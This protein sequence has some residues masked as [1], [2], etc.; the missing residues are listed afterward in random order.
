MRFGLMAALCG[1]SASVE[2][3]GD[4]PETMECPDSTPDPVPA[5]PVPVDPLPAVDEDARAELAVDTALEAWALRG[6]A[7]RQGCDERPA[8][9]RLASVEALMVTCE[10]ADA[11]T[12]CTHLGDEAIYLAPDTKVDAHGEPVSRGTILWALGCRSALHPEEHDDSD[13]VH[14]VASGGATT[15]QA[16]AWS[17]FEH[18]D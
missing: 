4:M 12:H 17:L 8:I 18:A 2:F 11:T 10:S 9:I 5:D 13:P 1:C 3:P 14:W 7:Q 15:T 16:L 6:H